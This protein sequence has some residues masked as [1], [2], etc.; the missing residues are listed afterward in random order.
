MGEAVKENAPKTS[1]T[2]GLKTE[3]KKIIWPDKQS[4]VR[5]TIAVIAVSVA[6]GVITTIIDA[7]LKYGV[8]IIVNL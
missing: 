1:W 5:Q 6:L 8:D 7:V 3:F 4:L 2:T